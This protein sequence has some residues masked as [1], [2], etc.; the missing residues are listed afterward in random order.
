MIILDTNV[1]SEALKPAGKE[2]VIAWLDEQSVDTLYLSATSLSELLFGVA[3]MPTGK[4][5][6]QIISGMDA[7][8][9]NL[10]GARILP[11][12]QDAAVAYSTLV[13]SA[14]AAG[15]TVSI[16]DGQ[17]GAIASVHGYAVATRDVTPFKALGVPVINPWA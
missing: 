14:R 2:A 11:F 16:A 6:I 17:I 7:L 9:T 13:S 4:R 5:K 8:L 10:F 1:V 15:T 3:I 12:D